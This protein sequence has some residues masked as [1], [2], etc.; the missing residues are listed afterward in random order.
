MQSTHPENLRFSAVEIDADWVDEK[1]VLQAS[2][3]LFIEKATNQDWTL[4]VKWLNFLAKNLPQVL[5][6]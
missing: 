6:M 1:E 5:G 4:R 2:V 3:K